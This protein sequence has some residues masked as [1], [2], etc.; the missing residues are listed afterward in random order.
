LS[1]LAALSI[2][3][4]QLLPAPPRTNPHVVP[5]RTIE[6]K[7]PVPAAVSSL[8]HRVCANCHSNETNW[9]W[10]ARIA[11]FSWAI[12]NDVNSARR[13]MNLSE[14]PSGSGVNRNKAISWLAMACSD[15]E[16][17]RM[18]LWRYRLLHPEARMSAQEKAMLCEWTRASIAIAARQ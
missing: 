16:A 9:P 15:V 10:Y 1:L 6:A 14:W 5:G 3:T 4:L 8:L 13:V 11:P 18:P 2:M 7:L 12:A 17:D